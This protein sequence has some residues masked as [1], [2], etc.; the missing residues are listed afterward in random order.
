MQL[1]FERKV[2]DSIKFNEVEDR[3]GYVDTFFWCKNQSLS[4]SRYSVNDAT[5][6]L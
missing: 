3:G 4:F 6:S 5:F 1:W 2:D